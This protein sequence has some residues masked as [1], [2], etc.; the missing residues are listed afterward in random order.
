MIR[1]HKI[2]SEA[3]GIREKFMT[4]KADAKVFLQPPQFLTLFHPREH[5]ELL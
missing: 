2:T 5:P 3:G 4:V 1:S